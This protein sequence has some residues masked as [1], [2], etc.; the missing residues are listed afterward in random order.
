METEQAKRYLKEHSKPEFSHYIENI[1]A[2]DFAV[3]LA[4]A[5]KLQDEELRRMKNEIV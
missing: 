3:A 1:L 4:K 5:Y 2:G